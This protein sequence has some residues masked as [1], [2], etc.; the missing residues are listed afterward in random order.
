MNRSQSVSFAAETSAAQSPPA[1]AAAAQAAKPAA[2]VKGQPSWADGLGSAGA[3]LQPKPQQG[4]PGMPPDRLPPQLARSG[5]RTGLTRSPS[6]QKGL[7]AAAAAAAN[8]PSQVASA[9]GEPGTGTS[10]S[11][12]TSAIGFQAVAEPAK[13]PQRPSR[14]ASNTNL[15][16]SNSL[17]R[18]SGQWN[19]TRRSVPEPEFEQSPNNNVTMNFNIT[20]GSGKGSLKQAI[21]MAPSRGA[22]K[23]K[24]S[25]IAAKA[26]LDGKNA[27]YGTGQQMEPEKWRRWK[28]MVEKNKLG[29][30]Y[31]W[32]CEPLAADSWEKDSERDM[33]DMAKAELLHNRRPSEPLLPN[34][35][36][37]RQAP[38]RVAFADR[39]GRLREGRGVRKVLMSDDRPPT[40]WIGKKEC[41]CDVCNPFDS[42]PAGN[43]SHLT[44]EHK[45]HHKHLGPTFVESSTYKDSVG[46][47]LQGTF[48]DAKE[49]EQWFRNMLGMKIRSPKHH[50]T[51]SPFGNPGGPDLGRGADR[52]SSPMLL[53]RSMS[54]DNLVAAG[55]YRSDHCHLIMTGSHGRGRQGWQSARMVAAPHRNG[56]AMVLDPQASDPPPPN[57][58][59]AS[60]RG[61]GIFKCTF[62]EAAEKATLRQNQQVLRFADPRMI[63][64]RSFSPPRSGDHAGMTSAQLVRWRD[65]ESGVAPDLHARPPVHESVLMDHILNHEATEKIH[66]AQSEDR[67]RT[68][69]AFK[70][71]CKYTKEHHEQTRKLLS[72]LNPTYKRSDS[73]KVKAHLAWIED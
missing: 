71:I 53:H 56:M 11:R 50:R 3:S 43:P 63:R 60:R 48:Q 68:D 32:V 65:R 49:E 64:C 1:A 47:T 29:A 21:R 9:R 41:A 17:S 14:S 55:Q 67:L 31:D 24:K 28:T 22:S 61:E 23:T 20:G 4:A 12:S 45:A 40:E 2:K 70:D 52:L 51:Y 72:D 10:L 54:A 30:H 69:P 5:S 13:A 36:E 44:A 38:G 37:L 59:V 26:A 35:E 15:N 39:A 46:A 42:K 18:A 66:R 33:H 16:G 34:G 27:F 7:A 6:Q 8:R 19:S 57:T 25:T 62:S 73:G 58:I